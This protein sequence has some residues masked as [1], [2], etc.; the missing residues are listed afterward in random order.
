MISIGLA[1]NTAQNAEVS[2]DL[3]SLSGGSGNY[4]RYDFVDSSNGLVL[5]SGSNSDFIF[6]NFSGVDL[7]IIVFDD[8][9]CQGMT[10]ATIAAFDEIQTSSIAVTRAISCTNSGEN[11]SIDVVSSVTNVGTNPGNYEFRLLPSTTYQASNVFMN[12]TPGTFSFGA[13]NRATGCEVILTHT[14]SDPNT[15]DVVVG[16]IIGCDLLWG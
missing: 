14:V 13:R 2:V 6:T 4:V 16:E 5:Q 15:F 3:S 9:G 8:K 10:T 11:I 12:L 1:D 7:D